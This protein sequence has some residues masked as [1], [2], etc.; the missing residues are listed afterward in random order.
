LALEVD[1][2][3]H[4]AFNICAPT[5]FMDTPTDQ[6]LQRYL[7]NVRCVKRPA[8]RNWAGYDSSKAERILGFK[9]RHFIA[10]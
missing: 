2:R 9:A 6:L 10:P 4:E 1:F 7:P 3:G 8:D 5:T